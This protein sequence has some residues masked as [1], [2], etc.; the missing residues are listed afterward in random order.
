[1]T[2]QDVHALLESQNTLSTLI[3]GNLN[4]HFQLLIART[5]LSTEKDKKE[6][7]NNCVKPNY[8]IRV[9]ALMLQSLPEKPLSSQEDGR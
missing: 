5:T 9:Y 2:T 1:M 4:C 8:I 3:P 7:P 6:N